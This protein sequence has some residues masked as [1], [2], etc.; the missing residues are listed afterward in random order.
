MA[1]GTAATIA[2]VTAILATAGRAAAEAAGT[3]LRID[4]AIGDYT[5]K[6]KD[7]HARSNETANEANR[8][9]RASAERQSLLIGSSGMSYNTLTVGSLNDGVYTGDP[10]DLPG[11]G[12]GD[13]RDL[14]DVGWGDNRDLPDVGLGDNRD[15]G[16]PASGT[17]ATGDT[18]SPTEEGGRDLPQNRFGTLQL[19]GAA[20]LREQ[21]AQAAFEG[22]AALTQAELLASG[23]EAKL[24]GSGV[25]AN[26]SPLLAAQQ[27]VDLAFA[28]ANRR[29]ESGNAGVALGGMQLRNQ[30]AQVALQ[31]RQERENLYA[32]GT[33]ATN[34]YERQMEEAR[35]KKKDLRAGRGLAVAIAAAGG[36]AALAS[37]FYNYGSD[38]GW[39]D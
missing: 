23:Q 28:A 29:I 35:R 18:G 17:D 27:N 21:G 22:R 25:R 11:V 3:R 16:V 1:S 6:I 10:R 9:I 33:L 38:L 2:A 8:Q 19:E 30:I 15:G 14:P 39:F 13:N 12:W 32:K 4:E 20:R 36:T 7:I 24:G 34:E 37:S 26:A 5:Q 31:G